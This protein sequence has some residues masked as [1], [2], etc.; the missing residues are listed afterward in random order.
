VE[1]GEDTLK[2]AGKDNGER[3]TAA[4]VC[5]DT[6]SNRLRHRADLLATLEESRIGCRRSRTRDS[7]SI[8]VQ[9]APLRIARSENIYDFLTIAREPRFRCTA[10]QCDQSRCEAMQLRIRQCRARQSSDGRAHAS[11]RRVRCP[12]FLYCK[13]SAS[14]Y[15]Q[16]N[17][18]D[19]QRPM[20][21]HAPVS[22]SERPRDSSS[23]P[24]SG[25]RP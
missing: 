23:G 9:I 24:M 3:R 21:C 5:I 6:E 13:R 7:L 19:A 20:H 2:P 11:E 8:G 16:S 15:C 18:R 22:V 14:L 17:D 4:N 1:A 12:T 25:S 10:V